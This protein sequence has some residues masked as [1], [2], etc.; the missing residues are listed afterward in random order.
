[1]KNRLKAFFSGKKDNGVIQQEIIDTFFGKTETMP[2]AKKPRGRRI[3]AT[4]VGSI[5]AL[6]LCV[7]FIILYTKRPHRT[8]YDNI[9][10]NRYQYSI[11]EDGQVD[12]GNIERIYFD[13]DARGKSSFLKNSIQ[14]VNSGEYGRA[15]LVITFYTPVDL[16]RKTILIQARAQYGAKKIDLILKDDKNRF[17]DFPGMTLSSN[18]NVKQARLEKREYFDMTRTKELRIEFGSNTTGNNQDATI[19]LK[20]I[21]I[22]GAL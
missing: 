19:Y 18:W 16:D 10:I 12:R 22:R 9:D 21:T 5:L 17:C 20:R 15:A 4:T 3:T 1:M 14:L 2:P 7:I 11:I 8:P 6:A 13:G